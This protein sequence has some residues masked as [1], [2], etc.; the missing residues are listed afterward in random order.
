MAK[1]TASPD[2]ETYTVQLE[3][4]VEQLRAE[5]ERTKRA[6]ALWHAY[7][8]LGWAL[9]YLPEGVLRQ[10]VVAFR[11]WYAENVEKR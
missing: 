7:G 1:R 10:R 11:E 9:D 2:W 3:T 6:F 8:L 4:E 5:N